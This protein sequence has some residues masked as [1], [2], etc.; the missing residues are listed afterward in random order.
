MRQC[1]AWRILSFLR[2]RTWMALPPPMLF[3]HTRAV[4]DLVDRSSPHHSSR[5]VLSNANLGPR[6][7]IRNAKNSSRLIGAPPRLE[8]PTEKFALWY[9]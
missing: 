7:H 6:H 3:C 1:M 9:A 8:R 5:A 2:V 4:A